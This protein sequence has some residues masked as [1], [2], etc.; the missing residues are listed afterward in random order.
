MRGSDA[1]LARAARQTALLKEV[2]KVSSMGEE[3]EE[4]E[5]DKPGTFDTDRHL[6]KERPESLV[7]VQVDAEGLACG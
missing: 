6:R 2:Q 5:G 3:G 7:G 4:E 1:S